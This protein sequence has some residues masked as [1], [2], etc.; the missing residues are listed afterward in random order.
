MYF[1]WIWSKMFFLSNPFI[2][3]NT[4]CSWIVKYTAFDS[5]W[6]CNPHLLCKTP[7]NWRT[8]F[9]WCSIWPNK[10]YL[11]FCL[12]LCISMFILP[13]NIVNKILKWNY[14]GLQSGHVL[15]HGKWQKFMKRYLMSTMYRGGSV[16]GIKFLNIPCFL[17]NAI[18]FPFMF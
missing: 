13:M 12:L 15:L 16:L 7:Y 6:T 17:I 5:Q 18:G 9:H 4:K 11:F 1:A 14:S 10:F 8:K 3:N 2:I